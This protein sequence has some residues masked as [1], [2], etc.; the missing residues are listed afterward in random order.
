M[1]VNH[2]FKSILAEALRESAHSYL[3][4]EI[5]TQFSSPQQLLD[6]T[7]QELMSIRGIG[8]AKARQ[9]IAA[10]QLAKMMNVPRAENTIIRN[11][12]DVFECL[13]WDIGHEQ[14]EH[15]VV[16]FLST[17]NH[18]IGKET[19]SIGSLNSAIVHPREVYKAA[20]R[21]SACSIVVSHNH[22]SQDTT[23]SPE[24]I[25]LTKRLAEVGE[26]VGIELLDHVILSGSGY[27]SLKEMGCFDL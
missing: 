1:I 16:L 7:E 6:V 20:I 3:I 13:R 14:K 15:F 12:C 19:I 27:T 11:P 5:A 2:T 25:Q 18:V 22:P 4:E 9:I 21:R 10:I 26:V 24:D 17:K 23:P 8:R